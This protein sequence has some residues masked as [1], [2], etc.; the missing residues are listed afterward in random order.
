MHDRASRLW[1][2]NG[3]ELTIE[4]ETTEPLFRHRFV[5]KVTFSTTQL[6]MILKL[7]AETVIYTPL[8]I[9][10]NGRKSQVADVL[11]PITIFWDIRFLALR[12]TRFQMIPVNPPVVD[13]FLGRSFSF[14]VEDVRQCAVGSRCHFGPAIVRGF[15]ESPFVGSFDK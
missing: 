13:A 1:R 3:L 10:L 11:Y 5:C 12:S 6:P 15:S 2:F 7:F 4:P 14:S 9:I 8:P